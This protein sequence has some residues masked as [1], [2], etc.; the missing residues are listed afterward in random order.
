MIC[1]RI[2]ILHGVG[3]VLPIHSVMPHKQ[4]SKRRARLLHLNHKRLE[5]FR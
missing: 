2:L 5:M 1:G 4:P 3:H